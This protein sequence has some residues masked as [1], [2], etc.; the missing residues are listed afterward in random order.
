M[1][2]VFTLAWNKNNKLQNLTKKKYVHMYIYLSI[3]QKLVQSKARTTDTQTKLFFKNSKLL[4]FGRQIGLIFFEAFKV[5]SAKLSAPILV[6]WVPCPFFP[7]FNH[8]FYKKLS[9]YSHIPNV[10]LGLG[11]QF[12]P[13]RI[14]NIAFMCP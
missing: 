3:I 9:L 7:L 6:L 2:H 13:Q 14:T 1:N 12:G 11:F 5:F 10:Y 4:G 8:Y